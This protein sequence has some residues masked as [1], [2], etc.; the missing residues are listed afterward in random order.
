MKIP[1]WYLETT[2]TAKNYY[3]LLQQRTRND[4]TVR[5]LQDALDD[6]RDDDERRFIRLNLFQHVPMKWVNVPMSVITMKR[7]R[8]RYLR[9]VARRLS[10]EGGQNGKISG[11][12]NA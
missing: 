9:S 7:V 6:L 2:R 4:K 1:E 10:E 11:L 3:A 8:N 12:D 5:A